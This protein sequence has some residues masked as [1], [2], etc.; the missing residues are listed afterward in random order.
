MCGRVSDV[1]TRGWKHGLRSARAAS[2]MPDCVW[3][4]V[5]A[6]CARPAEDKHMA[7]GEVPRNTMKH[8]KATFYGLEVADGG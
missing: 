8:H 6:R 7:R 3:P 4:D 1:S 2:L 5:Q